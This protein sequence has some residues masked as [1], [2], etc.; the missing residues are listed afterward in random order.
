MLRKV[1]PPQLK[2][3]TFLLP[4]FYHYYPTFFNSLRI[5]SITVDYDRT[6]YHLMVNAHSS[7]YIRYL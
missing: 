1:I 7:L 5:R 2:T 6:Y 3:E 4:I